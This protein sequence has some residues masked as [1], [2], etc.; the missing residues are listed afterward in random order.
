M[1]AVGLSFADDGVVTFTP[2]D[3]IAVVIQELIFEIS[4]SETHYGV[5]SYIVKIVLNLEDGRTFESIYDLSQR[6]VTEL[7]GKEDSIFQGE[8]E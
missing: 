3:G 4:V 7:F 1:S 5:H 8:R 2:R 6:M